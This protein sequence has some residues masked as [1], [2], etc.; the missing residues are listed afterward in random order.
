MRLV[1]FAV[2]ACFLA[3]VASQGI[4]Y[5]S[6][7]CTSFSIGA[8][9]PTDVKNK[10]KTMI[11]NLNKDTTL[12]AQKARATTFLNKNWK[13][14]GTIFDKDVLAQT[15]TRS[16]GMIESRWKIT[17]Y[18]KELLAKLKAKLAAAK[19]TEIKNM[20]WAKDKTN[21]N[22]AYYFYDEWKE[23][24]LAAIP[25]AAKKTEITKIV[26]EYEKANPD[27][28]AEKK[29]FLPGKGFNKCSLT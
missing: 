27:F 19:F 26:A 16:T 29:S 8:T 23:D 25:A 24:L 18:L 10:Y 2:S 7:I 13:L 1:T 15:I 28:E 14:I 21:G 6:W 20:L 22:N 5:N 17:T 4:V 12:K 11:A 3:I 9:T